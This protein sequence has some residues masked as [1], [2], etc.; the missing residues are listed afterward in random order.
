MPV[1]LLECPAAA[2]GAAAGTASAEFPVVTMFAAVDGSSLR[3][4]RG[5]STP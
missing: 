2:A 5:R 3:T 4:A 1:K